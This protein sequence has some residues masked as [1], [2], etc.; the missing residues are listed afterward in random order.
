MRRFDCFP[1]FNE[2]D[3]LLVRLHELAPIIDRF[4]LVEATKTHSG[5]D[6]P[7]YFQEN[8]DRF[9][10][11][12]DKIVH[13][14]AAN[15]PQT[16]NPWDAEAFQR[17]AILIGLER[18]EPAPDDLITICDADEIPRRTAIESFVGEVAALG[19]PLYYYY[20]NC[21]TGGHWSSGRICRYGRL[22]EPNALRSN[23]EPLPGLPD[24]GWHFSYLG[25]PEAV[26]QKLE[27]FAHQEFNRPE[28]LAN[29]ARAIERG[30]P[31]WDLGGEGGRFQRVPID[32]S[33]PAFI[34]ENL[35]RFDRYIWPAGLL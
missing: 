7:L 23:G 26:R 13:V 15:L 14:V 27:A 12:L 32:E 28:Y 18:C 6:K 25:G 34:R 20:L 1:F 35:D 2:L 31:V 22:R 16:G 5:H 10:P 9:T 33:Y 17:N 19:M 3:L 30:R 29:I 24:A 8:R 11:F 4:V 21:L